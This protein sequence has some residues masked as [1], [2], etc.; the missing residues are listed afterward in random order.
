MDTHTRQSVV[1]PRA[2]V[3]FATVSRHG[4]RWY[5]SLNVQAPDFHANRR[6]RPGPPDH[7][8][9]VGVDLGLAAFAVAA[10]SRGTEVARF[11][12]PKPLTRRLGRL[13]LRSRALSRT[14]PR[15]RNRARAIRTLSREHARVARI[16]RNFLHEASSH[17]AKTHVRMAIED[18]AVAN[19]VRNRHVARAIGDAAWAEFVRQLRYKTG[20]LGGELVTCDRWFASTTTCMRCGVKN[21]VG[22]AERVYRCDPC[23]LAMDRDR[24]AAANLAAWAE[25][26]HDQAPDRQ[27]GGR[28]TNAHGGEG[29]DRQSTD[30][31]TGPDEVGTKAQVT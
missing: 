24:N 29:N 26:R 31:A 13:R 17:L 7:I 15:S 27:A 20:W 22:L 10:T 2:K 5:V 14:K 16:R 12:A 4:S 18:L 8:E 9:F 1:A 6:H 30:G 23:G 25:R 28:V 3:L 11:T 19:L 21:P